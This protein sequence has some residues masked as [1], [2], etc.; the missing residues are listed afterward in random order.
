MHTFSTKCSC[1]ENLP[2][3]VSFYPK[4]LSFLLSKFNKALI[5]KSHYFNCFCC[6]SLT[7]QNNILCSLL[8]SLSPFL[9]PSTMLLLLSRLSA[10][11]PVFLSPLLI[12]LSPQPLPLY[13][14][15]V[16]SFVHE[17][18]MNTFMNNC[19]PGSSP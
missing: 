15:F 13:F 6:F 3:C 14:S 9:P 2:F 16:A 11:L 17:L 10:L 7:S 12:S 18:T 1:A 5:K 8:L 4:A 19:E